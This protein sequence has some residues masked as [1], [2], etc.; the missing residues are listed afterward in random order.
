M[1]VQ[2]S[3]IYAE[4]L[5]LG[6]ALVTVSSRSPPLSLIPQQKHTRRG[7]FGP[8][9]EIENSE[10]IFIFEL[11]VKAQNGNK[12]RINV[13]PAFSPRNWGRLRTAF[14]SR[15]CWLQFLCRAWVGKRA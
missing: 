13:I 12:N 8:P 14:C 9:V 6:A 5:F 4:A 3:L 7:W 2:T 11:L 10:I 15:E 1:S